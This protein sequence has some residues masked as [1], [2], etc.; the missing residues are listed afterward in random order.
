MIIA[1]SSVTTT[2][3]QEYRS[4][5]ILREHQ[6]TIWKQTD[7][8]FAG[9]LTFQYISGIVAALWISPRTWEGTASETHLH[10]WAAI[11]LGALIISLPVSLAWLLPARTITRHTIAAG[12]MLYSALLIHLCGGR[13]ETHF[14]VFGSLAFLAFYRDW[15]VLV[16]A[17]VVVAADHLV[18]GIFWPL[19]VFGVMTSSPWRALEHAGW[20][21]FEDLFLIWSCV[22]GFR[23]M[24]SIAEQRAT[25]ESTNEFVETQVR[26]RTADLA[27][28]Q[29]DLLKSE[30]ENRA[31]VETAVDAII[32][33]DPHGTIHSAN[34]AAEHMFGYKHRDMIGR[35]VSLLLPGQSAKS[36]D[37]FFDAHL[38]SGISSTNG[39]GR[40]LFGQRSDGQTFPVDLSVSEVQTGTDTRCT[41]IVRDITGR[42][43]AEALLAEQAKLAAFAAEIG[44]SLVREG[45][46]QRTLRSCAEAMVVQLDAA[47]ARIWTLNDNE[48][49]LELGASAGQETQFDAPYGRVPVGQTNIGQIAQERI[50]RQTN[51][52]LS[53]PRIGDHEWAQQEGIVA[54]A[55]HPLIVQDRV[56]G[57]MAVFSRLP[58]SD[59]TLSALAS[60]ADSI[61]VGIERARSEV[62]LQEAMVTAEL[63]NVAKSQFL[64]N[65]SHE[66]RTPM[67]AIIGYSEML[68]EEFEDLGHTQYIPD[69]KKIRTAGKHLLGLINDILDLSKIEAGKMEVFAEDFEA[70]PFL[71]DVVVTV[72][73][74]IES[75]GNTLTIESAA[76][77][78]SVHSD[79]TKIR[80]ILFNLLSNAAKFTDHGAIIL[81]ADRI[82]HAGQDWLELEVCDTGIGMTTEQQSRIFEAFTQAEASTTRRFGGTGLG[83]TI[84][85]RFSEMLGGRLTVK[86]ELGAGSSF[87]V[88]IPAECRR[89]DSDGPPKKA[90]LPDTVVVGNG[91]P[92]AREIL[93]IDDEPDARDLMRRFLQ[94]EGYSVLTAASGPEGLEQARQ[95]R[96]A[97]ITLDV[98]MTGM[99]GWAVLQQLKEDPSTAEIPVVM[100][101]MVDKADLGYALGVADYLIKPP[102]RKR[103]SDIL[104]RVCTDQTRSEILIVDDDDHSR[105]MLA[106]LV[107]KSG[108]TVR[109]AR[110]GKE[111]LDCIAERQPDLMLLDLQ[112][113]VMGGFEVVADLNRQGLTGKIPIVVLTARDVTRDDRVRLDGQV[114]QIRSKAGISR[115]ELLREINDCLKRSCAEGSEIVS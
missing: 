91:L 35:N 36:H 6:M 108:C 47:V 32:S 21:L 92:S 15:K 50:P 22:L 30:N 80:Q 64:A 72:Q 76:D 68:T 44:R 2:L 105:Q 65:M 98:M 60:V 101:S 11:L 8:L 1:R 46:L 39:M 28:S 97:A 87:I 5:E 110:N 84:T 71:E 83:L 14:H 7:R 104:K 58:L 20:V 93:V 66:L 31:I 81:K 54:F 59:A 51:Q 40:E 67:N 94:K 45:G 53:D 106:S 13:I 57:V 115:D 49:V 37:I 48:Q 12:Q 27:A 55:G 100:I 26:E 88:S 56:V 70:A 114:R 34:P 86:S 73:S 79:Q 38:R 24:R 90:T 111:A 77:L 103:L 102:D 96:P 3:T 17:T 109:Q 29:K 69:V 18:R 10:V 78:G 61:A 19:S 63:A 4:R 99:D 25:L 107:A 82:S 95:R 16:T 112:M 23:E 89:P 41:G 33:I 9:L 85:R 43:Q 42:R 62:R 75:R 52:V 113:P 74:L